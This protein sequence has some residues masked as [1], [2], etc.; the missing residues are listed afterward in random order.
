MESKLETAT[1]KIDLIAAAK[2]FSEGKTLGDAS[3]VSQEFKDALYSIAVVDYEA[4]RYDKAIKSLKFLVV[5]DQNNADYWALMGNA[6]KDSGLYM[7]AIT[8]WNMAMDIEPKFKTAMVIARVAVAIKNKDAAREGLLMS[9]VHLGDNPQD[10]E[11]YQ[12]LLLA[13]EEF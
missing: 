12:K 2:L 13:Y 8:A 6:L 3:G 7:E 5:L 9:L 10:Q 4:K 11:D 1:P